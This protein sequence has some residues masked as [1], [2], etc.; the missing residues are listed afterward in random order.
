MSKNRALWIELSKNKRSLNEARKE[1]EMMRKKTREM[2][3]LVSVIQR[4]W[5]QLDIDTSLLLDGLADPDVKIPS[6]HSQLLKDFIHSAD[7]YL[8]QDPTNL[9]PFPQIQADQW[10]N[11][12][13]II[14]ATDAAIEMIP[15]LCSNDDTISE[16]HSPQKNAQDA[17]LSSRSNK[18]NVFGEQIEDHLV[19]HISFT[20]SILERLCYALSDGA[21]LTENHLETL[22]TLQV[23]KES[24]AKESLLSDG[25]VKL[26]TELYMI[27]S[28]LRIAENQKTRV[29]KQLDKANFTIKELEEKLAA[30]R[31]ASSFIENQVII[32]VKMESVGESQAM[33]GEVHELQRQ[34]ALL[35]TQLAESE[36]VKAEAEMHL[37]ERI[38]R[39]LMQADAQV[40]DM[41]KAMEDLRA[42]CKQRVNHL[43]SENELLY[44]K[45]K[46]L[47]LALAQVE[48]AASK[49]IED[50]IFSIE[51]EF[52]MLK[53]EKQSLELK[54]KQLDSTVDSEQQS[55]A[56][57]QEYQ[58]LE[59]SKNLRLGSLENE[60]KSLQEVNQQLS[61][62]LEK[63]RKRERYLESVISHFAIPLPSNAK[64]KTP[65]SIPP[66]VIAH[67]VSSTPTPF[68]KSEGEDLSSD[69]GF[70]D[71]DG[72][73]KLDQISHQMIKQTQERCSDLEKELNQVKTQ[74]NDLI[75]EIEAVSNH[76]AAARE[77][78]EGL[79]KRI[80]ES[81]SMQQ[82]AL[83][84][85]L[86]LMND[87]EDTKVKK[88]D[89]E[90]K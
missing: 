37:T 20:F 32:G 70:S 39:P 68:L 13:E 46:D 1:L 24:R 38:S 69:A 41:R 88:T 15:K 82:M 49:K 74:V 10:S 81:H 61:R 33:N 18:I 65:S 21:T 5:S 23:L 12:E 2:E 76:E 47:Q 36:S 84:E 59:D 27:E 51:K 16:Q 53:Q 54:I 63:S 75:T 83:D 17:L 34:I 48:T 35:E 87:L 85:N 26:E 80:A 79:I 8:Y 9:N 66:L 52:N 4:A 7:V 55:K 22:K 11:K 58:Q 90:T 28:K 60:S 71:S 77:Q 86:K 64:P 78:S 42:Q 57:L 14:K 72:K 29:E 30:M 89:A 25:I 3:S 56:L 43:L 73:L 6:P 40:S 44:Q 31:S 19:N 45:V 62:N 67:A 50:F